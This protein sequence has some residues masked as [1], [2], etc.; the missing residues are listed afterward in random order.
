MKRKNG[1][2]EKSLLV[3]KINVLNEKNLSLE[4]EKEDRSKEDNVH[5]IH[6]SQ[7]ST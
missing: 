6:L 1:K 5:I 2:N 3:E 4:K 7:T